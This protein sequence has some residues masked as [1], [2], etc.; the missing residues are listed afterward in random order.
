MRDNR[1]QAGIV[2]PFGSAGSKAER[3]P[4]LE[5]WS[6]HGQPRDRSELRLRLYDAMAV[7]QPVRIG[8]SLD[9]E[10]RVMLNGR[11]VPKQDNRQNVSTLG[12][13]GI[14]LVVVLVLGAAFVIEADR[15]MNN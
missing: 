4:R 14:G 9:S 3:A 7:R 11:E 10:Q 5:A 15:V 6:D 1:V 12:W 8:V 2:I 13:V